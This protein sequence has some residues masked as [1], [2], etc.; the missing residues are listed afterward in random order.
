MIYSLTVYLTEGIKILSFSMA[1]ITEAP[2]FP[3]VAVVAVPVAVAGDSL[4][5]SR[6]FAGG[7]DING[8]A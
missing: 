3:D 2:L 8:F 6:S 7:I 5:S 1:A 4:P